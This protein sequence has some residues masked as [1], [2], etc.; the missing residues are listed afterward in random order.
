MV[1]FIY[2]SIILTGIFATGLFWIARTFKKDR[3][4]KR[5]ETQPQYPI[6]KFTPCSV[7]QRGTG[8][9]LGGSGSSGGSSL[10]L[11][12]LSPLSLSSSCFT[13]HV[14]VIT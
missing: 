5:D 1:E 2:N 6:V 7:N 12:P 9:S 8:M 4:K 11:S 10:P 14:I 3:E 13:L